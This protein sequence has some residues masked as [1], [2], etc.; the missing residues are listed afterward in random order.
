[1]ADGMK[2][3]RGGEKISGRGG[4]GGVSSGHGGGLESA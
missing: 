1:M 3:E 4:D 2:R